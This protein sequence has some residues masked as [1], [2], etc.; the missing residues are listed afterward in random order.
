MK[1]NPK[2]PKIQSFPV[3]AERPTLSQQPLLISDHVVNNHFVS[4]PNTVPRALSQA[5][6]TQIFKQLRPVLGHTFDIFF[7]LFFWWATT[8]HDYM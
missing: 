1:T 3:P 5:I 6:I 4:Q 7:C 8:P 2:L